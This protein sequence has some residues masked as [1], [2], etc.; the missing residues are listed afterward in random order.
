MEKFVLSECGIT[1]AHNADAIPRLVQFLD[2]NPEWG[3]EIACQSLS[4]LS[5]MAS[6]QRSCMAMVQAGVIPPLGRLL[7]HPLSEVVLALAVRTLSKCSRQFLRGK[8]F[9]SLFLPDV[10]QP[11][12]GLLSSN[13]KQLWVAAAEAIHNIADIGDNRVLQYFVEQGV[14][15][16]LCRLSS[17]CTD[18]LGWEKL[19]SVIG[20]ITRHRGYVGDDDIYVHIQEQLL[21][22][23]LRLLGRRSTEDQIRACRALRLCQSQKLVEKFT[24]AT[25]IPQLVPL[26]SS[27][28]DEL[29][30][31]AM[32]AGTVITGL[33]HKHCRPNK[34]PE[35][36]T[37]NTFRRLISLLSC[38]DELTAANSARCISKLSIVC[39][40]TQSMSG[41]FYEMG[42]LDGLRQLVACV[43][44]P[45]MDLA[46]AATG[47]L[48]SLYDR[49]RGGMGPVY[50]RLGVITAIVRC[51]TSGL[52][53]RADLWGLL[54]KVTNYLEL[55]KEEAKALVQADLVV[56]LV[57]LLSSQEGVGN[58]QLIRIIHTFCSHDPSYD[59]MLLDAGIARPLTTSLSYF[60][61]GGDVDHTPMDTQA[62]RC[63]L[64]WSD[65]S[66]EY[67]L[68]FKAV[69]VERVLSDYL[70]DSRG[71]EYRNIVEKHCRTKA[72]TRNHFS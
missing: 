64:A 60:L 9:S 18:L 45:N 49:N 28:S 38:S 42:N 71:K 59:T 69:G 19:A 24:L 17:E 56:P 5:Q 39:C 21:Q 22:P 50:A 67:R 62:V 33:L 47:T 10:L 46:I 51:S 30:V 43:P 63:I 61:D 25:V 40:W 15:R 48:A 35:Y 7:S 31:E 3:H 41:L 58:P 23:L 16:Q 14:A 29:F 53:S 70:A 52:H 37:W 68:A 26:L 13:H 34:L 2:P 66:P 72:A 32:W 36:I 1:A 6:H 55:G 44:S 20:R 4:V 11:L 57:R 65:C 27:D 54:A 12:I 8:V